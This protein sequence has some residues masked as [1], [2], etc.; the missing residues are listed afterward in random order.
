MGLS[1]LDRIKMHIP[2]VRTIFRQYL[3]FSKPY[4]KLKPGESCSANDYLDFYYPRSL[5]HN[6][7]KKELKALSN[8]NTKKLYGVNRYCWLP[9]FQG[10]E[11]KR[12]ALEVGFH[13]NSI[14]IQRLVACWYLK[15]D[16]S[17]VINTKTKCN[18]PT[19][20][21]PNHL[22]IKVKQKQKSSKK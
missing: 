22:R 3:R 2:E 19:C 14:G 12:E 7:S 6:Y 20:L 21:N 16:N 10:N 8:E 5:L 18:N 1:Q 9:K 11:P 13:K 4:P 17:N 15:V